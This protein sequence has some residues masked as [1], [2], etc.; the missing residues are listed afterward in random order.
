MT[1]TTRLTPWVPEAQ[2]RKMMPHSPYEWM[3]QMTERGL[4]RPAI[5]MQCNR[6]ECPF[7][8]NV[9]SQNRFLIE[10]SA[11]GAAYKAVEAAKKKRKDEDARLGGH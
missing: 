2:L 11:W 1:D 3:L 10:L 5:A 7:E 4:S 6:P 9:L 8:H